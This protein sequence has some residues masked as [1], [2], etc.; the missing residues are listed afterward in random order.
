MAQDDAILDSSME[1]KDTE[2]DNEVC[3]A[4]VFRMEEEEGREGF[5]IREELDDDNKKGGDD[6]AVPDVGGDIRSLRQSSSVL[7]ILGSEA[8]LRD[9]KNQFMELFDH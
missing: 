6:E 1:R 3:I 2:I 4:V 9:R 5:E 7:S 8:N